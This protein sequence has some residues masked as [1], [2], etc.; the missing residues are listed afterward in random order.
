MKARALTALAVG[1]F[2]AGSLPGQTVAPDTEFQVK[3]LGPISTQT[4][5]KG[6]KVTAQV[7]SPQQFQ[8]DI[9]EGSVRESKS[10][11]KIKGKSVL[12]FAFD[13]LN[14]GG[15]Q[16]PIQSSLKAVTNSKGKTGVDE[17]G[18]VISSKNNLG[19]A[20]IATG[21]GALIGAIAGGG[22]GAAIGAGVG[23]VAAIMFIEIGTTGANVAFDS[24]SLFT[25]TV[26][27]RR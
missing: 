23:A 9:L 24:G 27:E 22:K 2:A 18:R 4:S 12:N 16:V 17:E 19:K 21:A 3:L 1:V 13:V 14:H 10:G 7:Q 6:D 26:K 25:L 20:A 11:G 5:K 8:G 15:Q